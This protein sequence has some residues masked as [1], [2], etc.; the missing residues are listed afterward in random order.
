MNLRTFIDKLDFEWNRMSM[1]MGGDYTF[2]CEFDIS[3]DEFIGFAKM[4]VVQG[5]K[6]GLVNAMSNAK[7][8]IECQVDVTLDSLV[9]LKLERHNLPHKLQ[10]LQEM[11]VVAPGIL[12]RVNSL[13][14]LLEHEYEL[15]EK[16]KV[17]DAVDI[18]ELFVAACS[19]S[20]RVFPETMYI[21]TE[22]EYKRSKGNLPP[23]CLYIEFQLGQKF[24]VV[25]CFRD[26]SIAGEVVVI[27]SDWQE[28]CAV[29]RLAISAH[30]YKDQIEPVQ[31]FLS[32]LR[33]MNKC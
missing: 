4:D 17:E 30:P 27:P 26:G 7:R 13:R 25:R 32:A 20:L 23:N 14:N 28:F 8:A 24:F 12:K 19:K 29:M 11:G 10:L 22:E 31:T 3:P 21:A 15:P 16:A 5:D 9:G 1:V 18:A 6:H 33:N 2:Y